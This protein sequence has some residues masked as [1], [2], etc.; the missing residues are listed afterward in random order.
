MKRI[1]SGI[2]PTNNLT[3]GNYLGAILPL[4]L[5]QDE[6]EMFLFVADLH[7]LTT[8]LFDNT[9]FITK[10]KKIIATYIACGLD[11][12]KV[13]FFYQSKVEAIPLLSHILLCMSTLGELE[14]MTQYKDKIQN[15][16]NMSNNT[17][18]IPTG[19]LTYP[20]LMAADI[21]IFN[22]DLIPVG[23]DQKQH[24]ELTRNLA[25]RFNQRYEVTFTMPTPF[26]P[27]YGSRIMD[28]QNPLNKM[29][30]SASNT[31]GTIFLTDDESTIRKKIMSAKTDS[32]NNVKYDPEKQPG[33]TN[34]INIF[35][36]LSSNSIT[37]VEKKY[38]GKSYGE[39]K[40]DVADL[41]INKLSSINEKVA[42][43]MSSSV[44]DEVISRGTLKAND[45]AN[46]TIDLVMKN[47]K[48]N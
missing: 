20:T 11:L 36:A 38:E 43:L 14:R 27:K 4:V 18:M 45:V 35:V 6:Y 48:F 8:N 21:L 19:L 47:M 39:F 46:S 42:E 5:L 41:V 28:L 34:L 3:L 2:Q 40:K 12:N 25:S 17:K 10:K 37:D 29:S 24:L 7:A 33:V 23:S 9:D 16:K 32:L 30:K 44:L 15:L 1:L 26:I 31:K 13:N 22:A